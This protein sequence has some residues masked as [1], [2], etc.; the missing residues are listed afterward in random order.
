MFADEGHNLGPKLHK[1]LCSLFS[2]LWVLQL[3]SIGAHILYVQ[4]TVSAG[5]TW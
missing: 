3:L 4:G 5:M 1:C 2:L